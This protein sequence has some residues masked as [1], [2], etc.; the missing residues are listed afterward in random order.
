MSSY[1]QPQPQLKE[2]HLGCQLRA[3][4]GHLRGRR[5]WAGGGKRG[6]EKRKSERASE[7]ETVSGKSERESVRDKQDGWKESM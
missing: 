3:S 5:G 1:I 4:A 2:R 6:E 7:I